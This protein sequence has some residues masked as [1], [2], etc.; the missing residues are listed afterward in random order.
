MRLRPRG[1]SFGIGLKSVLTKSKPGVSKGSVAYAGSKSGRIGS[2]TKVSTRKN[3]NKSRVTGSKNSRSRASMN[4]I[5]RPSNKPPRR[6]SKNPKLLDSFSIMPHTGEESDMH[7]KHPSKLHEDFEH[8]H[9]DDDD[10]ENDDDNNDGHNQND[11][12]SDDDGGVAAMERVRSVVID[13]DHAT[14]FTSDDVRHGRAGSAQTKSTRRSSSAEFAHANSV[15]LLLLS[16]DE[17]SVPSATSSRHRGSP[18][19]QLKPKEAG[20]RHHAQAPSSGTQ[21]FVMDG[22]AEALRKSDDNALNR[23]VLADFFREHAPHRVLDVDSLLKR[24]KG[25][26]ADLFELLASK[27]DRSNVDELLFPPSHSVSF[28]M[29]ESFEHDLSAIGRGEAPST[30][31]AG[32]EDVPVVGLS[33]SGLSLQKRANASFVSQATDSSMVPVP[34]RKPIKKKPSQGV[35]HKGSSSRSQMQRHARGPSGAS[36]AAA[37]LSKTESDYAPPRVRLSKRD[38]TIIGRNSVER[39]G[40][41]NSL[42][43]VN[44]TAGEDT[45]QED[46]AIQFASSFQ[47]PDTE[48]TP[49]QTNT[50]PPAKGSWFRFFGRKKKKKKKQ[51]SSSKKRPSAPSALAKKEHPITKLNDKRFERLGESWVSAGAAPSSHARV[52]TASGGDKDEKVSEASSEPAEL[53]RAGR[54]LFRQGSANLPRR[55]WTQRF[56]LAPG[57]TVGLGKRRASTGT[58]SAENAATAPPPATATAAV[59]ERGGGINI[60][61]G[62]GQQREIPAV[63]RKKSRYHQWRTFRGKLGRGHPDL[64]DSDDDADMDD[65]EDDEEGDEYDRDSKPPPPFE[66]GPFVIQAIPK[67]SSI[68]KGTKAGKNGT[69][70]MGGGVSGADGLDEVLSISALD[71]D[72]TQGFIVSGHRLSGATKWTVNGL[73]KQRMLDAGVGQEEVLAAMVT[74]SEML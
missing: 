2:S 23:A 22:V 42:V 16:D 6:T 20:I 25:R 27:V 30:S 41:S 9:D 35:M 7:G 8:G 12:Q 3:G 32:I 14:S 59:A 71:V 49:A 55:T 18:S 28:E 46:L 56:G 43:Y 24:Y 13:E 5:R 64:E 34:K 45:T 63:R 57:R 62:E 50:P 70:K 73:I 4:D 37:A 67:G 15:S 44:S 52:S 53:G 21:V 58:L 61:V 40:T 47:E 69:M 66:V 51:S 31:S 38:A 10:N 1:A 72:R 65:D 11:D 68:D 17:S 54:F 19:M 29:R 39:V 48:P 26:E 36:A 60:S 74:S 33:S